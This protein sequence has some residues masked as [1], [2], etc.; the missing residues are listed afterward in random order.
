[1][2][3]PAAQASTVA[4]QR[5][6][7]AAAGQRGGLHLPVSS[8]DVKGLVWLEQRARRWQLFIRRRRKRIP[9][10]PLSPDEV[11]T[12]QAL[13]SI[14]KGLNHLLAHLAAK[15]TVDAAEGA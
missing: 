2:A 9:R 7:T 3:T 6:I 14:T 1:M 12:L 13:L 4:L 8:Q 15:G 11:A 10:G 5:A